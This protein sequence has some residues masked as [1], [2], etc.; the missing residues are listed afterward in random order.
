[1]NQRIGVRYYLPPLNREETS[2]YLYH[3]LE[4]AGGQGTIRF[5]P[6]AVRKIYTYSRGIPRLINLA[7][8]RALLAGFMKDQKHINGLLARR[9]IHSLSPHQTGR[10]PFLSRKS[11]YPLTLYVALSL[12]LG[13]GILYW[14]G[15]IFW[16]EE[17]P[18]HKITLTIPAP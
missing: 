14:M 6:G 1:L 18:G 15:N 2:R 3:R 13:S 8:D 9:G 17:P 4:V 11:L 7:A 5:S 10:P 16:V 12:A